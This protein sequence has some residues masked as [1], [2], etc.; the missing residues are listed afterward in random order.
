MLLLE[1]SKQTLEK[2]GLSLKEWK[3]LAESQNNLCF[4]CKQ[5]P[6]KGRLCIDHFHAK[7]WKKKPPEE[8]KKYVRGLLCWYCN[9]KLLPRGINLEKARNI[10]KYLEQFENK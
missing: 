6:K 1:P 9:F 5:P 8:R 2:Y 3:K 7:N 10:V 4:V